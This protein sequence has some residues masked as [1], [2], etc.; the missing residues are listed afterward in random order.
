MEKKGFDVELA[1]DGEMGAEYA[2]LGI[3][4][5]LI[6][7]VMMPKLNGYEVARQVRSRHLRTQ[8]LMLK[9]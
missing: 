1:Y 4:D 8:I 2:R 7:D 9:V 3:Y 6:L 5:L